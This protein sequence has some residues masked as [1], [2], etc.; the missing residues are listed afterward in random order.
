MRDE[1][2]VFKLLCEKL[3]SLN[4]AFKIPDKYQKK[5]LKAL[6]EVDFTKYALLPSSQYVQWSEIAI[7]ALDKNWLS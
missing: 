3:K 6:G 2:I 1:Q 4:F 7:C 5:I